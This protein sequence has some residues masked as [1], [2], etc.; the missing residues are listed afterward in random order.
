MH[1]SKLTHPDILINPAERIAIINLSLRARS[2][3]PHGVEGE[4]RGNLSDVLQSSENCLTKSTVRYSILG[5]YN[6]QFNYCWIKGLIMALVFQYGSNTSSS[7]LNSEERLRGDAVPLGLSYTVGQFDLGFTVW[8]E[9][10][11][12][13][14]A[15]LVPARGRHAWGVLYKI[16]DRL[17]SKH[18]AGNRKSLDAIE[19]SRYRRR[20]IK[21]CRADTPDSPMTVW[22]YTVINRKKG[23]KT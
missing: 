23:L 11:K 21:V 22:T 7:R 16:P 14:A 8:S 9:T 10:N 12:C 17:L 13:A 3:A 2:P 18:T 19:G 5:N 1:E 20:K 6:L 4:G 15:D